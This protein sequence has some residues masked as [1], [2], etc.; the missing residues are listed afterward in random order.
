MHQDI[1][2]IEMLKVL[3]FIEIIFM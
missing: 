1:Q 2:Y 3:N